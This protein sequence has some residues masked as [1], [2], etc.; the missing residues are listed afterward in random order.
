[1]SKIVLGRGLGALIPGDEKAA[2]E[3]KK[4]RTVSLDQ[5]AP[6]PMQPRRDFDED[7]LRELADSFRTNGIMQP[8]V[9]RSSGN[10]YTIIAGERRF[11]AARLAG[12]SE[13]PVMAETV[14]GV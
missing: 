4:Y 3:T 6:N 2:E 9:V 14:F 1:M 10:G 12:F 13:V 7:R 8:L 11:R 5:I